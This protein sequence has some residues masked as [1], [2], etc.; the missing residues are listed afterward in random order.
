MSS[1]TFRRRLLG[2]T[3]QRRTEMGVMV[4]LDEC[5]TLLRSEFQPGKAEL[6][7]VGECPHCHALVAYEDWQAVSAEPDVMGCACCHRGC[8]VD[9]VFPPAG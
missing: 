2:L 3:I 8:K 7:I 5:R 6:E 9:E 1:E 4:R